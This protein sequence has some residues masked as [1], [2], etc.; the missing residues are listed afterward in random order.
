MDLLELERL[1]RDIE[2]DCVERTTSTDNTAKFSEAICAFSNDLPGNKRPGYLFVGATPEGNASGAVITDQLLQ[3]LASIRSDGNI[4][5]LPALNVQK[6][7]LAGGEMAV[8][9]VFPSPLPP[10]RY[11]GVIWVRIG[12]RRGVANE[13]EERI[14]SERRTF[15]ARTWDARPATESSLADLAVDL[16]TVSYRPSA[17]A[18]TVIDDNNRSPEEQL[19]ALRFFDLRGA[20][21]THAGV[22]LFAKNPLFFVPGAYFQFAQYDGADQ[23][24]RVRRERRISG[25]LLTV[26]RALD[27]L[28]EE[29]GEARPVPQGGGE[30]EVY[31]YPPRCLHELLMNAVIHRSYES[32]TPVMVSQYV[33]RIE[34]LSPGGL[35]GDL[36]ADEFPHVTAYRNPVIAEASKVLGFVN[37]FGRGV[38]VAQAEL[39]RNGSP[40]A[41]FDLRPN[42]V[43]VTIR[44]HP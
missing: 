6:F 7:R 1:L 27:A 30:R 32:N 36:T 26:M 3:N 40:P 44:S 31:A 29:V 24:S 35:Y 10:V 2:S 9:E 23:A 28:V 8:L 15:L 16:F 42:H 17:I 20:C 14:L 25:D 22:L 11:K 5:P 4:Q 41:V 18:R 19:A 33:D 39:Q 12:P 21:P 43:L 37:K 13:A 34:L 38:D